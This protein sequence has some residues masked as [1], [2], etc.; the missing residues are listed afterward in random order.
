ME[1]E[2]LGGNCIGR[3]KKNNEILIGR[4]GGIAI[5]HEDIARDSL[6][7]QRRKQTIERFKG[8]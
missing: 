5:E 3:P 7:W 8:N 2:T 4:A 1:R 6:R